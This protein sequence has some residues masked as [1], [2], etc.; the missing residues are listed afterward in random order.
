M[1]ADRHDFDPTILRE[2]DV[3]GVVGQTLFAADAYALGRAFGS[4]ARRRGATAIAVGYDGRHSSPDL[5]G[6]LIQGLSDCGL[7]VINVGRGPTPML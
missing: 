6:A 1:A 4:I 5:A 2:Y 7:H 3:R